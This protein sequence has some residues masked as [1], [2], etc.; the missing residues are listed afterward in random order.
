MSAWSP[1]TFDHAAFWPLGGQH[2]ATSCSACHAGGVFAGTAN[3]CAACH[4]GDYAATTA[5][6]HAAAGFAPDCASCH[7]EAAWRPSSF[8]HTATWPLGGRHAAVSCNACHAGG[9]FSGAPRA[10]EGCHL[11]DFAAT[12]DPPHAAE[13]YPTDCA[14]CHAP[15]GWVPNTFDHE[16]AWPLRGQHTEAHCYDCHTGSTFAGTPQDCAACHQADY[17]GAQDPRHAPA[18]FAQDCASCHTESAWRPSSYLHPPSWPLSGAHAQAS[19]KSCHQADVY[20]GTLRECEDCHLPSYFAT[21]DPPHAADGYP[22]DCALCHA[23]AGWRPNTFDHESFWPLRGRH[24][25]GHCYDCHTSGV[26]AGTP[27]DCAACHQGAYLATTDPDHAA[28]AFAQDCAGCHTESAWR[29]ATYTHPAT[30][31]LSGQH[32]ATSCGGCHAGGVFAGTPTACDGCH[33]DRYLATTAPP[34]PSAGLGTN[35]AT[36]HTPATWGDGTFDHAS[37]PLTGAHAATPCN[38]CHGGGVFAGTP[39]TCNACHGQDYVGATNPSHTALSLSTACQTCHATSSWD[40]RTFPVHDPLFPI[41]TGKHR[42]F[43][44]AQC[45]PTAAV[46][47]SNFICTACHTGEHRLA[48]MNSEHADVGNYAATLA[49][50]SNVDHGCYQCHPTGQDD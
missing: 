1:A 42:T 36:C 44:C 3:T 35:C 37:W 22:T 31:P 50:A 33:H 30:W 14:R 45:H 17:T 7:T 24:A 49:A 48:E 6:P 13:G 20:A 47:W 10:C 19:C 34:H 40:T 29:P 12:T 16:S 32:L 43:T 25:S 8:V 23:P 5:P 26:Y 9:V 15:A 28:A 41:T 39:K 11:A 46:A 4:L 27:S 18:G 38:A 21:T 2:A